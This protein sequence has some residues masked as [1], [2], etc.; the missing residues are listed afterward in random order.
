MSEF[1][2]PKL[3]AGCRQRPNA[4]VASRAA[5]RANLSVAAAP[6]RPNHDECR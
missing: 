6:G 5:L 1:Y 2:E 4:P 3:G